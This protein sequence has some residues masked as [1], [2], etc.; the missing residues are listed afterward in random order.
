MFNFSIPQSAISA[1]QIG[2]DTA[3]Y[4]IAN[5]NT[6]GFHRRE[7]SFVS[8]KEYLRKGILMG[9]G[10]QVDRIKSIRDM[11]VEKSL[12]R[13]ISDVQATQTQLSIE[14]QIE[15]MFLSGPGT[16]FDQYTNVF[17]DLARL[18]SDPSQASQRNVVLEQTKQ[19]TT[20]FRYVGNRLDA[21]KSSTRQQIELEVSDLNKK[22]EELASVQEQ[23]N[24]NTTTGNPNELLDNRDRIINDIAEIIDVDRNEI[25]ADNFGVTIAGSSI[26]LGAVPLKISVVDKSDGSIS[27]QVN[28][29]GRSITPRGG[30]LAGLVTTH[31]NTIGGFKDKLDKLAAGLIRNFDQ[32]HAQGIG[33]AGS[34]SVLSSTRNVTDSSVPLNQV[35]LAFPIEA[36]QLYFTLTD[37]NGDV[38]TSSI[39]IDPATDSLDDVASKISGIDHL[40]AV[41]DPQNG[42]LKISSFPGYQFDFT[43]RVESIPDLSSYTG[44]SIPRLG[45]AY[46]GNENQSFTIRMVGSGEIGSTPGLKAEVYDDGGRLVTELNLGDDY[47]PGRPLNIVDGINIS[48][49]PGTVIDGDSMTTPLTANS[50]TSGILSALG[51]NSFFS[52]DNSTNIAVSA[53]ILGNP[54]RFAVSTTGDVSDA[55]N[56]QRMVNIQNQSIVDGIYGYDQYLG[57][58]SSEIGSS[59]STSESLLT[60]FQQLQYQYE[61]QRDSV[62][63]VDLNEE[64]VNLTRYQRSYEASLQVITTLDQMY[65]EIL[66]ILR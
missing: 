1:N 5:A 48:F 21:L 24:V 20:Q 65:Q 8:S 58:I 64:M 47:E 55:T 60:Q 13:S 52:G 49:A 62:S 6:P 9:A 28:E 46:V 57:G 14:S 59:V 38:R 26:T 34:F 22:I 35:G 32:A 12:S 17:N 53:N 11:V 29:L 15:G 44:S 42:Q 39:A 66:Q 45:G 30:R 10:V 4:N 23:I 33:V 63:G 43:G 2:I 31:N 41:V 36:G 7:T 40:N 56:L 51:L 25:S 37:A 19:L 54:A 27:L 3:A 16:L 50:D 61:S 18:S